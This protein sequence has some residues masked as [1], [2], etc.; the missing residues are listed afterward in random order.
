MNFSA[1][2]A[3]FL[4]LGPARRR[5]LLRF[6]SLIFVLSALAALLHS[7]AIE[8][9]SHAA[10]DDDGFGLTLAEARSLQPLWVDARNAPNEPIPG[11]P[12]VAIALSQQD[13]L[14]GFEQL[15]LQWMPPQPIVVF[16]EGGG[17]KASREVAAQLRAD[18]AFSNVFWLQGGT[19]A[20]TAPEPEAAP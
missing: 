1:Q 16:C 12:P 2:I 9:P 11:G 8:R 4:N 18:M 13:W 20:F 10:I 5:D 3:Y 17:C 15:L 7:M 14:T 19:A 6:G